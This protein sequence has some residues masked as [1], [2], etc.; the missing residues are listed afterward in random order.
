MRTATTRQTP[1]NAVGDQEVASDA[2]A[3]PVATSRTPTIYR[4]R[5][6]RAPSRARAVSCRH[7]GLSVDRQDPPLD[8]RRRAHFAAPHHDIYSLKTGPADLRP[9]VRQRPGPHSRQARERTGGGT[10]AAGVAKAHADVILISGHDGG[11]GAA[12]LSSLKHAGTRGRLAGR[13]PPDAGGQTV[14]AV[15][16]CSRLTGN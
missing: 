15:G 10:I 16:S 1:H 2:L 4:S 7:Q 12:P 8:S 13:S 3:S 5:W 9:Q 11:T 14:C 6:P